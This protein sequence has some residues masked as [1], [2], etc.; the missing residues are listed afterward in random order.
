MP[1]LFRAQHV[2][3]AADFQIAH[4]DSVARAKLRKLPDGGKALI[5]RFRKLAV[6]AHGKVCV[7]LPI[8]SAH[9]PANLV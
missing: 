1:A 7:G 3:R 9:A 8:A 4:G 6:S 2:A 5:R